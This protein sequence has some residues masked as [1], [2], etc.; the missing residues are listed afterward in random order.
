VPYSYKQQIVVRGKL[1]DLSTDFVDVE[2]V[3]TEKLLIKEGTT[4]PQQHHPDKR[5]V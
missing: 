5:N 1:T 4:I 3:L 2:E